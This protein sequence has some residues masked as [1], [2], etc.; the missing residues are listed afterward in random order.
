ML[1]REYKAKADGIKEF[2]EKKGNSDE[3]RVHRLEKELA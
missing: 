2:I 3:L 1:E